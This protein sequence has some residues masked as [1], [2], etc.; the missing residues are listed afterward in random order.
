[1]YLWDQAI[2]NNLLISEETLTEA[3]NS[4]KTITDIPYYYFGGYNNTRFSSGWY[5]VKGK[6]YQTIKTEGGTIGFVNIYLKIPEE[7][8]S[9]VILTNIDNRWGILKEQEKIIKKALKLP[10]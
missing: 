10:D 7:N 1:M 9:L 4:G 3:L 8:L 5:I 6:D 2:D